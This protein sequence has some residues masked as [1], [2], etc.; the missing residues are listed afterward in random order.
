MYD[1]IISINVH[2]NIEYLIEQL[3]NIHYFTNHLK[4]GIIYNCN[5]F[6]LDKLNNYKFKFY[7]NL[8][9]IIY[10]EPIEKRRWHGSLLK[11][12]MQNMEYIIDK[13]IV[14][15]HFIIA[16]SRNILRNRIILSNIETKYTDYFL[17]IQTLTSD[18]R[19]FYFSK[20]NGFFICDGTIHS[21]WHGDMTPT[22]NWFW[23]HKSVQ[24]SLWYKELDKQVDYFIGGRHEALCIP[25]EV[26][27]KIVSFSKSNT[28]I[29]NNCYNY[30]IAMEE[31]IPQL[32]A[33]K[34][35]TNEKMYILLEPEFIKIGRNIDVINRERKKWEK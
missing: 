3:E 28:E 25:Y 22:R 8:K 34:F 30:N 19:R 9:I 5:K 10:P 20:N 14:F 23:G 1:I 29:M 15:K 16:S 7:E 12:I 4:V 33:C 32:F 35:C 18:N 31:V 21:H 27:L 13:K 26:I 24:E 11:G 6:M 17:K 2:E